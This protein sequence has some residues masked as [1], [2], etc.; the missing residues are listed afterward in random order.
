LIGG[1]IE[2]RLFRHPGDDFFENRPQEFLV[3]VIFI[4]QRKI[5]I[6]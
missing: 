3:E 4:A 2:T 6:F 1:N 5:E